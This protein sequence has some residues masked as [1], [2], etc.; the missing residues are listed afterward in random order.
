LS[1]DLCRL[2]GRYLILSGI[3]KAMKEAV[4]ETYASHDLELVS[5]M[6]REEWNAGLW[7]RS[8]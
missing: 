2:T 7:V 4:Q 1:P 6:E 5:V 8:G 3:A